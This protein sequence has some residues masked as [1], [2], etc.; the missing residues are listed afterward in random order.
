MTQH[1][2]ISSVLV[3]DDDQDWLHLLKLRLKSLG[4]LVST[5]LNGE[6]LWEKIR[7]QQPDVILLD[8]QMK[9]ITGE[10]ICHS[11][12]SNPNTSNI[13]V[14]MYSSNQ[15]IEVIAKRCGANGY[16]EKSLPVNQFKA[17]LFD[18]YREN[19]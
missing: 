10:D 16:I 19:R 9:E 15:N 3:V 5:S 4:L 14:I 18:I 11:L 7:V 2:K 12:K 8:I 17:R 13:P 1:P 6:A